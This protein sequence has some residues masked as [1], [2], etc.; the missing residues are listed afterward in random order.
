MARTTNEIQDEIEAAKA[1]DAVLS[2]QITTTSNASI[3]RTI[4]NVIALAV[5]NLEL[6]MDLFRA[7]VDAIAARSEYGTPQWCVDKAKEFQYGDDLVIVNGTP[8]YAVIDETKQIVKQA[9]ANDGPSGGLVL[10]VAKESSGTLA[11]LTTAE[12][13]AF[14]Y[15]WNKVKFAG[16]YSQVIS[17]PADLLKGAVTVYHDGLIPDATLE[18]SLNALVTEYVQNLPFDGLFRVLSLT[19]H[20]QTLPN[21][22]DV[23]VTSLQAKATGDVYRA[24]VRAVQPASGYFALDTG[25]G[26][27]TWT[28]IA[29]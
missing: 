4:R 3:W 13:T 9:T 5:Y 1:A 14:S 17:L 7:E 28:L 26:G 11:A 6:I 21:V 2:V 20:I 24:V 25:A 18:Y 10:K 12:K 15:Y 8:T 29:E 19:D 16:I 22:T 23:V 27:I